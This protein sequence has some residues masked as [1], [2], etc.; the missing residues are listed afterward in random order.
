M[1]SRRILSHSPDSPQPEVIS[2]NCC[3][4][5]SA[6]SLHAL[7]AHTNP[8]SGT[9]PCSFI[10]LAKKNVSLIYLS[11]SYFPLVFDVFMQ[12]DFVQKEVSIWQFLYKFP[13]H[14]AFV[15][16]RQADFVQK[17]VSCWQFLYILI[18]LFYKIESSRHIL[19]A[20]S[21]NQTIFHPPSQTH[22]PLSSVH[23][24]P[25]VPLS[26]RCQNSHA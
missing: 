16:F 14:L 6:F 8:A 23:P 12:A 3:L 5:Q 10:I 2:S 9:R 19:P 13:F 17:E 21:F 20:C 24:P 11:K 7:S 18:Y 22:S 4:N 1:T 25:S 15:V 26:Q